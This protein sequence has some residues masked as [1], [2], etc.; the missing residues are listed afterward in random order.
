SG[1]VLLGRYPVLLLWNFYR[2]SLRLCIVV[3]IAA[4]G[5]VGVRVVFQRFDALQEFLDSRRKD[6]MQCTNCNNVCTS[7]PHITSITPRFCI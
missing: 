2:S 7:C 5:E 4:S 1:A 6:N 3:P